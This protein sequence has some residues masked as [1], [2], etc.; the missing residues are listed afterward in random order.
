LASTGQNGTCDTRSQC[1]KYD[2]K[3]MSVSKLSARKRELITEAIKG[4]QNFRFCSPSDDPEEVYAATTAYQYLVIQLKRL[5]CPILP[6]PAA[7]RLNAIDVDVDSISSA[8]EADAEL[9]ALLPDIESALEL[10]EEA[11]EKIKGVYEPGEAYDFYRDLS[12]LLLAATQG[13][14]IIDAYI[15]EKVFDLYVTKVSSNATVR[16]LS[17]KIEGNTETV[18]RMYASKR[19]LE[20]RSSAKVHDRT[21]FIDQRGWVIGQSIKDAARQ[22]PTYLVELNEPSLTAVRDAYDRIWTAAKVII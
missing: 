4:V 13:I 7:S 8:F 11:E 1:L 20:I 21:I 18:A 15:D 22:K 3:F 19:P 5:A 16:I 17:K 2:F 10:L 12:S 9:N 14:L 6:E